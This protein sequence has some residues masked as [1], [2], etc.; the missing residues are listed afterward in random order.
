ML[1]L[2]T[3]LK[4]RDVK[5]EGADSVSVVQALPEEASDAAPYIAPPDRQPDVRRCSKLFQVS[6]QCGADSFE[7]VRRGLPGRDM[8][9]AMCTDCTVRV[10][11]REGQKAETAA[12]DS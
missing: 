5:P 2:C 10:T 9:F 4:E 11:L 3:V 7:G 6:R 12:E 1:T 8:A